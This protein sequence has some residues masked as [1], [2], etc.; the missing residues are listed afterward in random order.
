MSDRYSDGQLFNFIRGGSITG[1]STFDLWK[2]LGYQGTEADFINFMKIVNVVDSLTSTDA[3]SALSANQGKNLNEKIE[4]LTNTVNNLQQN[5]GTGGTGTDGKDGVGIQSVVQTTTS[6]EDGGTN[7]VT[8]TLTD[9][10][11]STFNVKNGT[12]GATGSQGPKGDTGA[13]GAQGPKGDKGDT[14][15]QGEQGIQ[16]EKGADGKSAYA[17]AQDAGYTGSE[18]EFANKLAQDNSGGTVSNE[19]IAEAVES[20]LTENP[21]EGSVTVDTELSTESE[22]PVQNKVVS[23]KFDEIENMLANS[24]G[25]TLVGEVTL[26]NTNLTVNDT[27]GVYDYNEE[28]QASMGNIISTL[29]QGFDLLVVE[30]TDTDL[31]DSSTSTTI[32]PA[33]YLRGDTIPSRIRVILS[34]SPIESTTC[35]IDIYAGVLKSNDSLAL[36]NDIVEGFMTTTLKFYTISCGAGLRSN[37]SGVQVQS[38]YEQNDSTQPDYIKNRPFYKEE[39]ICFDQDVEAYEADLGFYGGDVDYAILNSNEITAAEVLFNGETY[40]YNITP[41][42]PF[43]GNGWFYVELIA[44]LFG[45][46]PEEFY[47]DM[48]TSDPVSAEMFKNTGEAFMIMINDTDEEPNTVFMF[49]EEGTYHFT[50][51]A[52]KYETLDPNF[53]DSSALLPKVSA[54]NDGQILGVVGGKWTNTAAPSSLPE[55]TTADND[56]VLMVVD[57]LWVAGSIADGDEVTY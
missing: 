37:T 24:A 54:S 19:Q 3:N 31:I 56:K 40:T 57:G 45:V 27:T 51:N 26:S 4:R 15:S 49:K 38:D 17:Y 20:Y 34:D 18:T 5:G 12:K 46:T 14:G 29:D 13:T 22:N 6:S 39:N 36:F 47:E 21:V 23:A 48:L 8:V 55:V 52:I 1:E 53:I 7:I 43:L 28:L 10:Q 42:M 32:I 25:K 16:G 35:M 2:S 50:I 9:G 11:T 41:E 30:I 33:Q 44:Q